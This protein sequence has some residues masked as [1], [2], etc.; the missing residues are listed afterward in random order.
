MLELGVLLAGE[1]LNY[2][3]RDISLPGLQAWQA[4]N[5]PVHHYQYRVRGTMR[6]ANILRM[7]QFDIFFQDPNHYLTPL[8]ALEFDS[9]ACLFLAVE[10]V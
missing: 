5:P 4:I 1:C 6:A 9:R 2:S 10:P 8:K 3:L 7:D